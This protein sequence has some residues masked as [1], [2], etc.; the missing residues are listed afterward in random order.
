M[1]GERRQGGSCDGAAGRPVT[2]YVGHR[3]LE[4]DLAT[5]HGV[6]KECAREGLGDRADLELPGG[7]GAES[8]EP[9][10]AVLDD[11]CRHAAMTVQVGSELRGQFGVSGGVPED[12]RTR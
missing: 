9:G 1:R 7:I 12:R 3:G 5:V 8:G 2:E 11:D 4:F 6:E 10:L